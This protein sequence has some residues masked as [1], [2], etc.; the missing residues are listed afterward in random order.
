MEPNASG[1][2]LI[3]FDDALAVIRE[4]VLP[5]SGIEAVAL[6]AAFGRVLAEEVHSDDYY[7]RFDNSAVD[8]YALSGAPGS[9]YRVV[10]TI[11]AGAEGAASL[12]P[13]AA[14]RVF[15]GAPIPEGSFGVVMQEDV[16]VLEADRIEVR[17]CIEAGENVRLRGSEIEPGELLLSPGAELNAGAIGLLAL[18]GHA[19]VAVKAQPRI[20]ILSTG[21]E[22]IDYREK[23]VGS[24][25]RDTSGPMLE[26][27]FAEWG[28]DAVAHRVADE[29]GVISTALKSLSGGADLIV[30][31]G[32][33]SVGG[34]D[35][36]PAIQGELGE[37]VFHGIAMRPGKPVLFGIIGECYLFG[38]PGNPASSFVGCHSFV[39]ET[40]RLLR[41]SSRG[42]LHWVSARLGEDHAA[43]SR[44]DFVRVVLD[45]REGELWAD[46]RFEQASFGLRSLAAC[47]GIARMPAGV[48]VSRGDSCR[49]L[50]I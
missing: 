41:G 4:R 36:L 19:Q 32:G 23:P 46:P 25:I 13:G 11:G 16:T 7:P 42:A 39:R 28:L 49:V 48:A 3:S 9:Q 29:P 6:E 50:V 1:R 34:R 44:D 8:G 47:D 2:R 10:E 5:L 15:T 33:V 24:Q 30:A 43:Y 37:V 31:T 27:M 22:L 14:A 38:L 12:S 35:Y 21:D 40:V 20:A 45:W 18:C 26:A 17:E